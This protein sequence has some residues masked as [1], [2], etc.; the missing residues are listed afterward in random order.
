MNKITPA[1]ISDPQEVTARAKEL[2]VELDTA[3]TLDSRRW[4]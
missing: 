1:D 2:S 4:F 3:I